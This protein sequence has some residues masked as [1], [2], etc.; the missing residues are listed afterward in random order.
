MDAES[1]S[2][3]LPKWAVIQDAR[4]RQRRRLRRRAL[5]LAALAGIGAGWLTQRSD[6]G[7]SRSLRTAARGHPAVEVGGAVMQVQAAGQRIWVLTC[8]R[9]C[10][11][12]WSGADT[13]QL[14]EIRASTETTLR[15]LR[16]AD[17]SAF[18]L[19]AGGLWVAHFKSG[20]IDRLNPVTGRVSAQLRLQLPSPI[21]RGDR[22][23][24]PTSL[25]AA[26]GRLWASTGRGLL[27]EIDLGQARLLR[28]VRTPSEDNATTT[29]GH[30][31]WVAEDLDGVGWLAP[32]HR[33]LIVRTVMQ[34]GLPLVVDSVLSSPGVV[35]AIA[36]TNQWGTPTRTVVLEINPRSAHVVR[37]EQLPLTDGAVTAGGALYLGDLAHGRIYRVRRRGVLQT[38]G[39]PRHLGWLATASPGA[40][41]VA[42]HATPGSQRGRLFRISLPPGQAG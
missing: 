19:A 36:T 34:A 13:E 28:L 41:W 42:S 20:D 5:L 31:T 22:R 32:Q 23:F 4:R 15:R 25:A 35:W 29:D 17:V 3:W 7:L 39:T 40:L 26:G 24:L 12:A 9:A 33:H 16:L 6:A 11:A 2:A 14:V 18:A 27:A 38:F 37:R 21:V 8:V 10:Q 1:L 30:G